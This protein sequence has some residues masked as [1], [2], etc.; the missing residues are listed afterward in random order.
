MPKKS[1]RQEI[2]D[3]IHETFVSKCQINITLARISVSKQKNVSKRTRKHLS[4]TCR[5][6][7]QI[8]TLRYPIP[9]VPVP[10]SVSWMLTVLPELDDFRFKQHMRVTRV[11][12]ARLLSII[13]DDP[14]FN[15]DSQAPVERQ[16][17]VVLWRFGH[18]GTGASIYNVSKDYGLGDG[19]TAQNFTFI[20]IFRKLYDVQNSIF[21]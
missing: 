19:G 4:Q 7:L 18:S 1:I 6:L 3:Q 9:R 17:Q 12:F 8:E 21:C 15:T 16:L 11:E 2:I 13:Q 14:I 10:K 5:Q 20:S